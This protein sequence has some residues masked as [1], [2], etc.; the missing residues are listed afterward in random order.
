MVGDGI[1]DAPAL[2][3][4]DAGIA[5]GG[6]GADL[7]AEAGDL[8]IL[9]DPLRNLP[10]LVEL[11]RAT[12]RVIRQNIIVFAFGLNAVA[13]IL[14]SLGILRPGGGGDPAPGRLAAR[15]AQRDAAAGLRRLGRAASVPPAPG[16]RPRGSSGSTTGWISSP[17][18]AGASVPRKAIAGGA[19]GSAGGSCTRPAGSRRSGRARSAWSAVRRIPGHARAG[20]APPAAAPAGAGDRGSSPAR[21]R[22]LD[23]GFRTA[24][25]SGGRA[26]PLGGEPRAEPGPLPDEDE[27]ESLL[28][29]GDGQFLEVTASVQ[30]AVDASRPGRDPPVRAGHRRARAGA[31]VPGRGGRPRGRR[32]A[33][34]ARAAGERP[35]R[36]GGGRDPRAARSG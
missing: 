3:Q 2:A 22:G 27:G 18:G 23:V 19:V 35:S 14:A 12:V 1:N 34:A 6:I 9:G 5:L 29:T 36:G 24:S 21:V 25:R 17:R 11:S 8:I 33:A 20:P 15:P 7:A 16:R 32:P 26:A 13:V 30:Y 31:P 4:A 10:A 28:L